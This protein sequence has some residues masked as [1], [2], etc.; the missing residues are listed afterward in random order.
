MTSLR[1]SVLA[2]LLEGQNDYDSAIV[3][4]HAIID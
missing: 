3:I 1:I 4:R 2:A